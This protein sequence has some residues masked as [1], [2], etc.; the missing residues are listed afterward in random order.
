MAS[1]ATDPG[2]SER[3]D[4]TEAEGVWKPHGMDP[5]SL[6]DRDE[7]WFHAPRAAQRGQ[8]TGATACV[9]YERQMKTLLLGD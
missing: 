7:E 8:A 2:H 5:G 6:R 1:E 4:R 9:D 3:S